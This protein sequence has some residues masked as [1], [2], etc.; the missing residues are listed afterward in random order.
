[1]G[2][3]GLRFIEALL[4]GLRDPNILDDVE[5]DYNL[6]FKR[7]KSYVVRREATIQSALQSASYLLGDHSTLELLMGSRQ[8]ENVGYSQLCLFVDAYFSVSIYSRSFFS[9]CGER[10]PLYRARTIR[11]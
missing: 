6:L 8:P 4:S 2:C 10:C 1:M 11:Y 5:W 9:C 7:F 3:T